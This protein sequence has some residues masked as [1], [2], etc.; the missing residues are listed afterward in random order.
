M[1]AFFNLAPTAD[2]IETMKT[3]G[4]THQVIAERIGISRA[5]V[6]NIINRQFGPSS[7]VVRRVL[8]LAKAA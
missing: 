4:P 6:T 3:L 7:S 1:F 8:D 2:I 5:Q